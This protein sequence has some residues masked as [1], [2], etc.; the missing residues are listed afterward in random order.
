MFHSGGEINMI[1]TIYTA[2]TLLS[3]FTFLYSPLALAMN[4][5]L[6]PGYEYE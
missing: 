6:V 1:F 2:L 5:H 3:S 4:Y